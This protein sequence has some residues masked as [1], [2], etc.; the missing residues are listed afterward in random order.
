MV[1][2]FWVDSRLGICAGS[3]R[4]IHAQ[5]DQ[6]GATQIHTSSGPETIGCTPQM[7]SAC[8]CLQAAT[9]RLQEQQPLPPSI[10]HHPHPNRRWY[11]PLLRHCCRQHN[12]GLT[13]RSDVPSKKSNTKK[14]GALTQLLNYKATHP[15]STVSFRRSSMI[16]HIHSDGSYLSAPKSCSRAGRIFSSRPIM[17]ILPNV[18]QTGLSMSLPKILKT[19]MGYAYET[20]VGASYI[21]G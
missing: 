13:W 12:A 20:E 18:H 16:L 17:P 7:E 1:P 8:L 15:N 4:Y 10:G 6:T 5:L 9:F 2:L 11:S 14:F 21:N 3:H 19:F